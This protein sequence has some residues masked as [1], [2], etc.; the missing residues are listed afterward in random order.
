MLITFGAFVPLFFV[1]GY[2]IFFE[3]DTGQ[4]KQ[5]CAAIFGDDGHDFARGACDV[6]LWSYI[7]GV[8]CVLTSILGPV[9]IGLIDY[10]RICCLPRRR[11]WVAMPSYWRN[12]ISPQNPDYRGTASAN[13]D[14]SLSSQP[15]VVTGSGYRS[16]TTSHFNWELDKSKVALTV[17]SSQVGNV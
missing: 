17:P 5:D 14:G 2:W 10:A 3:V 6:R 8:I 7:V 13:N 9:T 12:L 4:G 16:A 11:A 15:L 1:S